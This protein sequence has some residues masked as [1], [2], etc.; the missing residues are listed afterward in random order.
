MSYVMPMIAT[1]QG[2]DTLFELHLDE[3]SISSSV[4]YAT[5]LKA[6]TCRVRIFLS[7][8]RE[9]ESSADSVCV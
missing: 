1:S 9:S 4:N 6:E 7:L 8:V 5:F 2:F 3:L